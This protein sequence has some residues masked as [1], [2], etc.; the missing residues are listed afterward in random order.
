MERRGDC[1]DP[2]NLVAP[3]ARQYKNFVIVS[4]PNLQQ[5]RRHLP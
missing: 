2:L 1:A 3:F 4:E 5:P